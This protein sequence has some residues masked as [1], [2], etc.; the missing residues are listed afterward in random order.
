MG[1]G[2]MKKTLFRICIIGAGFVGRKHTAAYASIPNIKLQVICDSNTDAMNRIRDCFDFYRT[3]TDWREAVKADD[4]DI[5]CICVPNHLHFE[6]AKEALKAGKHVVCEKPLGMNSK[7][8][9]YLAEL[10]NNCLLKTTCC[11]NL[12]QLPAIQYIKKIIQ[13]K[14]L[15]DVVCFRGSY[16]NDRFA[17]PNSMFEWRMNKSVSRGGS[18][19]DLGLNIIAVSQYLIGDVLSVASM[20]EI[21]HTKRLD[22]TGKLCEV[23]NEDIVQFIY[24]YKEK[25]MGYISSNRIAPGSKQDM[26]FE[27]QLTRGAVR[28]SLE[29][30]N[31]IH[32]YKIG[33]AGFETIIAD[34]S[35]WFNV[36]YEELKRIDAIRFMQSIIENTSVDTDFGFAARIDKTIEAVLESANKKKWIPIEG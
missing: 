23:G 13:H 30:M 12:V 18:I 2:K 25:G 8:S 16:D 32:I 7:E 14:E 24:S 35:G 26:K 1:A 31:E 21:I 36:G 22:A 29:R 34:E 9:C 28:F 20:T 11:Y 19:C 3:E 17:D 4:V 27:I 6:I 15:G 5:V 33:N 10:S